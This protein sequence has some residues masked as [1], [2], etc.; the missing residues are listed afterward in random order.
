MH[1]QWL[2]LMWWM[3]LGGAW[4]NWTGRQKCST[5]CCTCL[6]GCRCLS[7]C[8]CFLAHAAEKVMQEHRALQGD[9]AFLISLFSLAPVLLSVLWLQGRHFFCGGLEN[10]EARIFL[11]FPVKYLLSQAEDASFINCLNGPT[12]KRSA[13]PQRSFNKQILS[14]YWLHGLTALRKLESQA[15]QKCCPYM[16]TLDSIFP[17]QTKSG[18]FCLVCLNKY[19]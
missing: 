3:G 15:A 8:S 19:S 12:W 13:E 1:I 17:L 7:S 10:S 14:H 11:N 9:T 16:F 18:T 4:I 2:D 6:R 5:V